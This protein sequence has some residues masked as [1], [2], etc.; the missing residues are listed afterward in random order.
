[1][2]RS[3]LLYGILLCIGGALPLLLLLAFPDDPTLGPS[4]LLWSFVLIG[5]GLGG[6]ALFEFGR[7]HPARVIASLEHMVS[8]E[9]KEGRRYQTRHAST[10]THL[11][12]K[13]NLSRGMGYTIV[14]D[15]GDIRSIHSELNRRCKE[16]SGERGP[17]H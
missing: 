17:S 2:R 5:F 10:L 14:G 9:L 7:L 12:V 4:A 16:V 11:M 1:M 8:I 13:V 3:R 6:W 15:L